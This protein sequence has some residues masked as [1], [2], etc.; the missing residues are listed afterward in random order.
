M[1]GSSNDKTSFPHKFLC[2]DTRF[3]RIRKASA[4]GSSAKIKFS[5]TQL[6]KMIQSG[7]YALYE[8][9][10]PLIKGLE[11]LPKFIDNKL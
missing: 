11:S 9:T 4:N 3:S 1:T 10:E 2:T 7:E 8:I 5:K 6:S